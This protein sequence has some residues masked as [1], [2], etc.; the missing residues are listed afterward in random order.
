MILISHEKAFCES[1]CDNFLSS[2]CLAFLAISSRLKKKGSVNWY[3]RNSMNRFSTG[4]EALS[5]PPQR[6]ELVQLF[7]NSGYY[8][9]GWFSPELFNKL[10]SPSS[11]NH[12][13]KA[14]PYAHWIIIISSM[15]SIHIAPIHLHIR[16][17][18]N[19]DLITIDIMSIKWDSSTCILRH[20]RFIPRQDQWISDHGWDQIMP[21][22]RPNRIIAICTW[23]GGGPV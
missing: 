17:S 3:G 8:L 9:L 20:S 13:Q 10:W 15:L 1:L 14:A 7:S 12:G 5:A 4:T 19:M 18:L 16:I 6:L 23:A 2:P 21:W 22:R 11:A